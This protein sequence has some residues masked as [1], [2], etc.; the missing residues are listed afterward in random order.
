MNTLLSNPENDFE[1]K[2]TY[3]KNMS[4]IFW[5]DALH[6]EQITEISKLDIAFLLRMTAI[7]FLLLDST[8]IDSINEKVNLTLLRYCQNNNSIDYEQLSKFLQKMWFHFKCLVDSNGHKI[9]LYKVLYT[10]FEVLIKY[11]KEFSLLNLFLNWLQDLSDTSKEKDMKILKICTDVSKLCIQLFIFQEN[12]TD[13]KKRCL[14]YVG[15]CKKYK[16]W[17]EDDFKVVAHSW[18]IIYATFSK[19]FRPLKSLEDDK[20]TQF[21]KSSTDICL[22]LVQHYVEMF[23]IDEIKKHLSLPA[24]IKYY[25]CHSVINF[26]MMLLKTEQNGKFHLNFYFM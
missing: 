17:K 20:I 7:E 5:N 8:N 18:G 24:S 23:S 25:L 3:I 26:L 13:F 21:L 9:Y 6:I 16:Q 15:C 2:M 22:I 19:F 11:V 10:W 14:Q 4:I 12:H 1:D